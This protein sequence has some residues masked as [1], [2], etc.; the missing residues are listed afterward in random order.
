MV[1]RLGNQG[2][3]PSQIQMNLTQ[4]IVRILSGMGASMEMD[5]LQMEMEIRTEFAM[6]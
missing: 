1:L 4:M 6:M 2:L 5:P 3:L